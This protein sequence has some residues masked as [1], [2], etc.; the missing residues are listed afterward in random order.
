MKENPAAGDRR[1]PVSI[2]LTLAGVAVVL[3]VRLLRSDSW[4]EFAGVA[5]YSVGWAMLTFGV[6]YLLSKQFESWEWARPDHDL[7][8]K[9]EDALD[10]HDTDGPA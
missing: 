9:F 3:I 1:W 4:A 2:V 6:L 10:A 7:K 8:Q 5:G